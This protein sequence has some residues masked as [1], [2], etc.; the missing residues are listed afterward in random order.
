MSTLAIELDTIMNGID[1]ITAARLDRAVRDV[2]ALAKPH[3]SGEK[4]ARLAEKGF[5]PGYFDQ[6]A[7]AFADL[8]FDRPPQGELPPSKEW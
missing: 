2:M 4:V 3:I 1:P 6:T 8:E 7:G 5:P